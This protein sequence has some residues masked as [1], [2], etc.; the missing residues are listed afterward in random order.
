M[1]IGKVYLPEWDRK[2]WVAVD[3]SEALGTGVVGVGGTW[4]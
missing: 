2:G 4:T 3:G 1:E